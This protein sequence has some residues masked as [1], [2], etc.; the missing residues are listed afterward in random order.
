MY[1]CFRNYLR[2]LSLVAT[3]L[4]PECAKCRMNLA[5]GQ[6]GRRPKKALSLVCFPLVTRSLTQI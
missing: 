6:L 4:H 2:S 3:H 5:Q 1:C